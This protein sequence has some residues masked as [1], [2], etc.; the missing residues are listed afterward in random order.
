M[1]KRSL[2]G[3]PQF[4]PSATLLKRRRFEVQ[5]PTSTSST[6]HLSTHAAFQTPIPGSSKDGSE[7]RTSMKRLSDSATLDNIASKRQRTHVSAPSRPQ[8]RPIVIELAS[9]GEEVLTAHPTKVRQIIILAYHLHV[10]C[11][12]TESTKTRYSHY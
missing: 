2:S 7:P 6:A 9:D 11:L 10:F 8:K 12:E 3:T 5:H 1:Q 4:P